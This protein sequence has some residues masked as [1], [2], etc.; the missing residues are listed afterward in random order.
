MQARH[1][2]T[3]C[4]CISW[5]CSSVMVWLGKPAAA[6]RARTASTSSGDGGAAAGGKV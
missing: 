1:A 3:D 6:A 5:N 2:L 4:A